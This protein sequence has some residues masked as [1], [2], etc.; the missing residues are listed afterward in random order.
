MP[1]RGPH[2]TR[3]NVGPCGNPFTRAKGSASRRWCSVKRCWRR[4]RRNWRR[5]LRVATKRSPIW[6]NLSG[7][8]QPQNSAAAWRKPWRDTSDTGF[9]AYRP[10]SR[11]AICLKSSLARRLT[12]L[13]STAERS[14]VSALAVEKSPIWRRTRSA[15]WFV[16]AA[17]ALRVSWTSCVPW[18]LI[19]PG[20][21]LLC[22]WN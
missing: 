15:T 1:G 17:W 20:H 21:Q 5:Q 10:S 8:T 9:W 11:N 6:T 18:R 4:F 16:G 12:I 13:V 3:N 2:F 7:Y 19:Q 14:I 22:S